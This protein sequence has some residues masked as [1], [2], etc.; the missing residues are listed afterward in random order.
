[1][2]IILEENLILISR[3]IIQLLPWVSMLPVLMVNASDSSRLHHYLG[4]DFPNLLPTNSYNASSTA[5]H[6]GVADR[7]GDLVYL[8]AL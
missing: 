6:N 7:C 4:V 1:M 8:M 2:W 3:L 5:M